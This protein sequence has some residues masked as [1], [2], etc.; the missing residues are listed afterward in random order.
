MPGLSYLGFLVHPVD[1]VQ[2]IDL[3]SVTNEGEGGPYT[4]YSL[5]LVFS[6]GKKITLSL[7]APIDVKSTAQPGDQ[8]LIAEDFLEREH[9]YIPNPY[10]NK[11]VFQ[12]HW[13]G[14]FS[15]EPLYKRP[16]YG[17]V[18]FNLSRGTLSK[19]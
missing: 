14:P 5:H 19:L 16:T 1:T 18:L 2:K 15:N 13:T 7:L 3:S 10:G 17:Q 6:T 8:V 4:I 9:V 12:K 11:R